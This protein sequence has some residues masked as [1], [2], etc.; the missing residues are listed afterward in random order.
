M[1]VSYHG[2][3]QNMQLEM[4]HGQWKSKGYDSSIYLWGVRNNWIDGEGGNA[5]LS[6]CVHQ[7]SIWF[8]F[9]QLH[10]V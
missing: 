2:K 3:S 8:E 4:L 6:S 5:E 7:G 9:V 1:Y 10:C